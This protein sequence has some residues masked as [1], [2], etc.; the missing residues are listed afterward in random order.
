MATGKKKTDTSL[1]F[2]CAPC[3]DDGKNTA[4][5]FEC[6][7]C[8]I[9]YCQSCVAGHNKFTKNH[10][11]VDKASKSFGQ[12]PRSLSS[13][14][15]P[16]DLCKEHRGQVIQMFCGQHDTVCC[17]ICIAVKHR[18]CDGVEYIP[19]IAKLLTEQD[20]VKTKTSLENVKDDLQNL[21]S[22]LQDKLKNLN[23]QRDGILD[24]I[25]KFN[26]RLVAKIE[27]LGRESIK[28]VRE[29]H[30]K[31]ANELSASSKKI[32]DML[33]NVELQLDKLKQVR[34]NNKAQLFVD[35]KGCKE[36]ISEGNDCAKQTRSKRTFERFV[37]DENKS[38]ETC[39]HGVQSLGKLTDVWNFPS[40]E[41]GPMRSAFQ[42][43]FPSSIGFD[44]IISHPSVQYTEFKHDFQTDFPSSEIDSIHLVSQRDPLDFDPFKFNPSGKWD[45][46]IGCSDS[47]EMK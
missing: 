1:V 44:S 41:I 33:T 34:R 18:S 28:D 27:E 35:M 10:S 11:V 37:F 5:L 31:I 15:L 29:K 43:V 14:E 16:T 6:T 19:N 20:K 3:S 26:R 2:T 23:V 30:Q 46:L 17:T 25:Q 13:G 38:I 47:E 45:P 40:S 7:D 42:R 39:L 4:A 36:K 22:T 32:D 8:Q 21:K 9:F 12:G 24:N